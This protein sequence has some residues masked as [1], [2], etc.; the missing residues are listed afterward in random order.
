MAIVGLLLGIT[1]ACT[2]GIGAVAGLILGI[3]SLVQV[4]RHP[5]ALKGEVLAIVA[6]V[7]S[8]AFLLLGALFGL[9]ILGLVIMFRNE[10][11]DWVTDMWDEARDQ[12]ISEDEGSSDDEPAGPPESSRPDA[13]MPRLPP[14]IS[15]GAI[16]CPVEL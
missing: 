16:P 7:V 13:L 5:E 1:G 12:A 11:R 8:A 14:L 3:V 9:P 4:R 2:C 15:T 6:I 10:V